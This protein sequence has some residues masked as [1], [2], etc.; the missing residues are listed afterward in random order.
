MAMRAFVSCVVPS[1][2]RVLRTRWIPALVAMTAPCWCPIAFADS[3]VGVDTWRANKLDPTAGAAERSTDERGTSWLTSGPHRSPSGNLY[4]CPAESPVVDEHGEW[5]S[6]GVLE[7]GAIATGGDDNN[8]LWNRY[9]AWDSGLVLGLLDYTWERPRDGTYANVRAS[10][11]SDDDAYYQAV[12]GR[13]GSYKIQAFLR[14]MPNVVSDSAKP[15]WNGVGTS[16]LTLPPSLAPGAST[17]AEIAAVSA[18]TPQRRLA[19]KRDKEGLGFSMFLTPEWT[20]YANVTDE[21]RKGA[22][23]YGGVFFFNYAVPGDGGVMETTRP[24]DDSTINVNGGFRYAG[25]VWRMDFGYQGS[26][27]RDRYTSYTY[28]SPFALT[29]VVPGATSAPVYLGQFAT[30]PDNDY[31][32]LRATFTRKLP[33]NGEVSLTASGGRMSQNDALIAP[34]RCQGVFGIDLD[35][36]GLGPQNPYLYDCANWNSPAALSRPNADMRIDTTLVDGR[37]VLQPTHD[38]TVRGGVRFDRE[39]YR[40]T[41]LAYNPLTGQYGYV[42][43]NGAQGS[44]VPGEAGFWD[45]VANASY[46]TRIM[47]L[48]L[49]QQTIDANLG[50]DFRIGAHDTLGVTY[51]FKRYEP[52]HRE[53]SRVDDNSVKL[54]WVDRALDWLTLRANY[55]YLKQTGD[56]YD[57]DPYEFTLSSGLPGFVVPPGGL[58]PHTVDALRK[59]DLAGRNESKLD[60]MATV[61]PRDDMTLT[62]SLRG[63]WNDYDAVLGRQKYDTIG[64]TLQWEWQPS[65][66]T[67]A[68]VYYGY[69]E[70]KLRIANVNDVETGS[71][72]TL[73]GATYPLDA[74]WWVDDKQRNHNAGITFTHRFGRVRFDADWNFIYSRGTDAYRFSSPAALAYFG[75]GLLPDTAFPPMTYRVNSLT[76]GVEIPIVDRVSLRVFDYYE[77]GRIADWHYLGF[78]AGR[79]YDHRVYTDG[80]PQ[81]YNANLLGILVSIRL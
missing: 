44:I 35:G 34:V 8:A 2:N 55:M 78:D 29:P 43:E 23:P 69:D 31:H 39:D 73:G 14:A 22:R 17:V 15:I 66:R 36:S 53:R 18:A 13:A 59:Y 67:S 7:V 20:A 63:D 61:M 21:Q 19:V 52:S 25:K 5:Q 6:Y 68:S 28:E 50:A 16:H 48:P 57:F 60:L 76:L 11:I 9:V 72:P 1:T 75:D 62:A 12:Y 26:F 33:M 81:S 24:I 41:Y 71:D 64:A 45:P 38:I 27:Y 47:S 74:R 37:I 46:L 77:R 32:N 30:E 80:G 49:D 10:R 4:L 40:N 58:L 51:A 42:T 3:G 54:S 56:R 70:A 79:V 65:P